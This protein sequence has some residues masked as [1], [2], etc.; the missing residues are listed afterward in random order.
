[1]TRERRVPGV[2][3]VLGLLALA[4]V[5]RL[6]NL[7]TRGTW[8]ADQGH[9]MLVLRAWVQDGVIPLLGPPTSIGDVHHGALYYYLL[10]PAAFLTGGDS[11]LAV[12]LTIALAGIAAVGVTWWLARSIG[13][14]VAGFVAGLVLAVSSSAVD[15]STFIWNPNLIAL[16]SAIALAGAWR[17]WTT[18][19]PRWWLLAA[20]GT[21]VT[22]QCHVLGIAMAPVIGGLLVLDWRRRSER[23]RR[24]VA[25]AGI[26]WL[27]I[28]IASYV[29][30]MV[31]ELT[32]DFSEVQAA[33]AYLRGGGDAGAAGPLE[34]FPI[35]SL[36]VISWPLSGL[37]TEAAVPAVIAALLVVIIVVLR[38]RASD[39]GERLA[40]R[41]LG[42]GLLWTCAFLTVAAPSLAVV[43]PDLPNDHYHAFA[44]PMVVILVGLGAGAAWRA[45]GGRG[46]LTYL[47]RAVAAAGVV[48]LCAWNLTTQP[49]AVNPDGGFPAAEV[50]AGRIVAL[51]GEEPIRL[52]S[53]PDFKSV[54]AYGYPLVRDGR[55][56]NGLSA[57]VAGKNLVIV[58]DVR[59]E[60]AI[61]ATCGGPAED[62]AA[63]N[64]APGLQLAERFEASPD[65]D[66][67]ISVYR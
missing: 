42:L 21:A 52:E 51:T 35:V 45:T 49:P 16:S 34:R 61:G 56:V 4:A 28:V 3:V 19:Q 58:C 25:R 39:E 1:M 24:S 40:V 48:V 47:P 43:V 17:A 9:D 38:W 46:V 6:P 12:V 59:F 11:P 53:L 18:E 62:A 8:D 36:R 13:G 64:E 41:W 54:D 27:V 22:V 26:A 67:I 66:R 33:L 60:T 14:A 55:S 10:A 7:A 44:D 15:G 2:V 20:A 65:G 63:A 37:I 30:L 29:P 57:D 31:H 5:L 23:D 32:S 50:A